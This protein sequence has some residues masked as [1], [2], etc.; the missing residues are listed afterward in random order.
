MSRKEDLW[1]DEKLTTSLQGGLKFRTTEVV[2][3]VPKILYNIQM[4]ANQLNL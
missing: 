1:D 4:Y 2:Q 3:C